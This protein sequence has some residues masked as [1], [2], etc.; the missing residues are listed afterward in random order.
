M[1][2]KRD[3]LRLAVYM[4]LVTSSFGFLQPF[5]PLYMEAEGL[6]R[7]EIGTVTGI[8][9][10][11][12]LMMQPILGRLSDH[13]DVRRPFICFAALCSFSAYVA[14]PHVT[15]YYAFLGLITLGNVG[16][17]YLNAAGG[18]LI[19]R[20][21]QAAKGGAAYGGLRLWGSV[22]YIVTS[23]ASG[24]LVW[25]SG[26]ESLTR[27]AIDPVFRLGPFLFLVLA[28]IAWVLPDTKSVREAGVPRKIEKAPLPI[29]LMWFLA[30][31]FLYN[32]ALYGAMGFLSLFLKSLGARGL[33][34]TGTFALGVLVE[35]FVMRWSGR[36]SDRY[37]RRPA[38]AFSFL[39][40]PLRLLMYIPATGP[41][42]VLGVQSL[43]GINFGIMGAVAVVFVNDLTSD[44][45]RGQ[46]QA[47]L[48]AVTGLATAVS[49]IVF[50]RIATQS[51]LLWMFGVASAI[52]FVGAVIFML[53]V[54]DSHPGSE[55]LSDKAP[56]SLRPM[57]KWLD[58]P[59]LARK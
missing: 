7:A 10:G 56:P 19:G 54:E 44:A 5:V 18:V 39:L 16:L 41:L 40:L 52:S 51:S 12:A 24:L 47:R 26:G 43:H 11:I 35:V 37:G 4:F 45:T 28:S 34:I 9:I 29:N 30:A 8:G 20:M 22:G 48:F 49:P 32:F 14:F 46:A 53:R 2:T 38:L 27:A 31:Y 59:L 42:W 57:L 25:K 23:C 55:S 33:A 58:T 3:F 13:F 15:G 50:G 17:M 6:D 21:V 1:T 36:F